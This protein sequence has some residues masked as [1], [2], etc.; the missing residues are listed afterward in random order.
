MRPQPCIATGAVARSGRCGLSSGGLMARTHLPYAGTIRPRVTERGTASLIS[1]H[2]RR[3]NGGRAPRLSQC[4]AR[5]ERLSSSRS[6]RDAR[7][8]ACHPRPAQLRAGSPRA[9]RLRDRPLTQSSR[10][11]RC[12]RETLRRYLRPGP[13]L[14]WRMRPSSALRRGLQRC[15][16]WRRRS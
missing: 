1:R 3:R 15:R 16:L 5:V 10:Q 7:I 4:D 8:L 2:T 6:L 14:P 9:T 13:G 12:L 11:A